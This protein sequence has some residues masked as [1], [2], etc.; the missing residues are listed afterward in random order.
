[1]EWIE[2]ALERR[3]LDRQDREYLSNALSYL[4]TYR[5]VYD[6]ETENI[7]SDDG[8]RDAV[9]GIIGSGR[10]EYYLN[11]PIDRIDFQMDGEN[12]NY[13]F[14]IEEHFLAEYGEESQDEEE[15]S[16]DSDH[17]AARAA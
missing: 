1:M 4:E 9:A 16:S 8:M 17:I 2:E 13:V 14:Y 6:E 12:W 3:D 10:N 11:N 15:G 5:D 7:G